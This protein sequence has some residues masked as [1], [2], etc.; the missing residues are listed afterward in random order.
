[1]VLTVVVCEYAA[2]DQLIVT[3]QQKGTPDAVTIRALLE[4]CRV[5]F[6]LD[7]T[8]GSSALNSQAALNLNVASVAHR[9]I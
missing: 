8:R 3:D 7:T 5:T 4:Y 1:M 9:S 2:S 6:Q